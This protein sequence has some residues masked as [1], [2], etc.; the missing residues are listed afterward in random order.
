MASKNLNTKISCQ[1]PFNCFRSVC[2]SDLSRELPWGSNATNAG[3][4]DVLR[5]VD[6][7][8]RWLG[9]LLLRTEHNQSQDVAVIF[10]WHSSFLLL[11]ELY[12]L[13]NKYCQLQDLV[14]CIVGP[15]TIVFFQASSKYIMF[16]WLKSLISCIIRL[17]H[18]D[19]RAIVSILRNFVVLR[20]NLDFVHDA[21]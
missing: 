13:L 14:L 1:T 15:S 21:F 4:G 9:S 12:I 5:R 8:T 16:W 10:S 17:T 11:H 19:V 18:A 3:A 20:G 7:K 6:V 2:I